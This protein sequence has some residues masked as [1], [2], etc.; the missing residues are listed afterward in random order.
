MA[1]HVRMHAGGQ[2][3]VT[4]QQLQSR[5]DLAGRQPRSTLADEQ[6]GLASLGQR[7]A[8]EHPGRQCLQ[9]RATHRHAAALRTLAQHMGRG[10]GAVDP[11]SGQG[12]SAQVQTDQ[13][14]HPQPTAVEQF[15]DAVV[16]RAQRRVVAGRHL[17]RQRDRLIDRQRFGQGFGRFGRTDAVHRV[18]RHQPLATPMAV[19]AAPGR[20]RNR[21]AARPQSTLAQPG[22]PAAHMV[23]LGRC[24]RN[25]LVSGELLQPPQR[26]R[27]HRQRSGGETALD[28][29]M[30]QEAGKRFAQRRR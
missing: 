11:A 10:V 30:L 13:L 21:D 1:Q 4:R 23:G 16:T 28:P 18:V 26:I 22:G 7:T 15:D 8:L 2:S 5:A 20:Q 25:V 3:G 14:A 27:I 29:Q 19:Q 17:L 6:R 9:R 24:Q 12:P